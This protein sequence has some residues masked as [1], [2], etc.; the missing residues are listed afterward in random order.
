MVRALM[1]I[2]EP[3]RIDVLI[4]VALETG[5]LR[6]A[7]SKRAPQAPPGA[8]SLALAHAAAS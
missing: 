2:N 1:K 4:H 3:R 5:L 7:V 6:V 8:L